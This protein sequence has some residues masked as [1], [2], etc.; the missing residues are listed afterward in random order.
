MYSHKEMGFASK[1]PFV[2]RSVAFRRNHLLSPATIFGTHESLPATRDNLPA[3]RNNLPATR[4]PRPATRD[5]RPAT[6]DI[7]PATR[8]NSPTTRNPRRLD[9]LHAKDL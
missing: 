9:F 1:Q 2:G 8:E 7:S 4:D 6:R 5:P 3:T